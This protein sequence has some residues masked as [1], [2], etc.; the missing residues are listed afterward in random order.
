MSATQQDLLHDLQKPPFWKTLGVFDWLWAVLVMAGSVYAYSRY[1]SLMD[2]YEIGIL[3]GTGLALTGLGWYW[4]SIR[5]L[6]IGRA[7]V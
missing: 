1:R 3:F 4:K 6:E 5:V 7:H 2:S